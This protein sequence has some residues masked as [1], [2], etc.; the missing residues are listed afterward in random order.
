[1]KNTKLTM[2]QIDKSIQ[3]AE[4]VISVAKISR[5]FVIKSKAF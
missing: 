1:M 2:T 4:D 5:E 3:E